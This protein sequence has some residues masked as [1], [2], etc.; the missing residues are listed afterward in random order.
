MDTCVDTGVVVTGG[1]V[2][3]PLLIS[4]V[5]ILA[6]HSGPGNIMGPDAGGGAGTKAQ[7]YVTC[8]ARP[9]HPIPGRKSPAWT[10][11]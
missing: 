10:K 8:A 5:T 3:Y 7:N 9:S 11:T 2:M 4:S 1:P 6:G